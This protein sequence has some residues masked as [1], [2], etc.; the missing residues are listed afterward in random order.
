MSGEL[1][2]VE[3]GE[4][5][6]REAHFRATTDLAERSYR[7]FLRQAWHIIEPGR[8]FQ[9]NWHIDVICEHLEAVLRRDLRRLII[10][11]PP[12]HLKSITTVVG[13]PSWVW[14]PSNDPHHKFLC[15]SYALSLAI[16][17][18]V[19]TRTLC[20]SDWYQQRWPG[21][22]GDG[23]THVLRTPQ[24]GERITTAVDAGATGQGGDTIIIDDPH[25]V[26]EVRSDAMRGADLN[27][28]DQVM[29]TRQNDPRTAAIVVIMQ[30]SH[31]NDATAHLLKQGGWECLMLP[32]EYEANRRCYV[33]TT[34]FRD[35]RNNDGE[36]LMPQRFGPKEIAAAKVALGTYGYA[37]QHQQ[38]PSP[39]G[40][41][42]VKLV[43]FRRYRTEPARYRRLTLSLDTANK[44]QIS[45]AYSTCL[46]FIE[47][48]QGDYLIDVWRDKVE[49]PDLKRKAKGL[50]DKYK[51]NAI[52][53]ENKA[54]GIQLCQEL[55]RGNPVIPMEPESDKV[56]RLSVE[57][58]YVE[59]GNVW[60]PEEASWL[61]DFEAE[62]ESFPNGD[63]MDQADAFSQ[64]L[65]YRRTRPTMSVGTLQVIGA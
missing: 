58:P 5:K 30:R 59:A 39:A 15:G 4:R 10:N 11:I 2:R 63:Y 51:P 44:G 27:W 37:G 1:A 7:N 47:T 17:D 61:F 8:E 6:I 19:K 25:N 26:Q 49:Y 62:M 57:S 54:S 21:Y 41:G 38:R 53:I 50:I 42:V 64:Y 18:Q 36:L 34:G 22:G 32:T 33:A 20:Q 55:R 31:S 46:V 9:P 52:L 60:L 48:E 29:S 65:K 28:I 35:P 45:A 12:R 43:W 23:N 13:F 56:T 24:S 14:L 16:R 3:V 40:G